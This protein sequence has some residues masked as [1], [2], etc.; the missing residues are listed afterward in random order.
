MVVP[1]LIVNSEDDLV[2]LAENIREDIIRLVIKGREWDQFFDFIFL[3]Q[4][5][6]VIVLCPI[7]R[8]I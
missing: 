7:Y 4:V 1:V 8:N 5:Y 6:I 2:C 3:L